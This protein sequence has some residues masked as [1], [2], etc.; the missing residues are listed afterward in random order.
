MRGPPPYDNRTVSATVARGPVPRERWGAKDVFLRS[1]HGEGQALALRCGVTFFSRSRSGYRSA[2]ACP[3]RS[4]GRDENRP[5]TVARG[6]VP[7]DRWGTKDVFLRSQ[8]GEGQAL[9]LRCGVTFFTVAVPDTVARG[10][11]PRDRSVETKTA[12]YRSA[13]ACPPRSQHGEGQALALR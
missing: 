5:F 8:H 6:P 13:G 3:P 10:P 1:Q 2:G 12:R 9:A 4:P 11:V 7:R